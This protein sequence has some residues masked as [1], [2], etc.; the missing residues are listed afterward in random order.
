MSLKQTSDKLL[1]ASVPLRFA[2]HSSMQ[3]VA[4]TPADTAD[5][6]MY[7]AELSPVNNEN[8]KTSSNVVSRNGYLFLKTH[9]HDSSRKTKIAVPRRFF[10]RHNQFKKLPKYSIE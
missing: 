2:R 5:V 8:K 10:T 1:E 9:G 4:R 6:N 3:P 7:A